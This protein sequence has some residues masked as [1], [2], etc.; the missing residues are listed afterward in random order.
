MDLPHPVRLPVVVP[1][2]AD[3][4]EAELNAAIAL[5]AR[6]GARRVIVSG[7]PDLETLAA[8]SLV[9]AQAAGVRFSLLRDA[10]TGAIAAIVGPREA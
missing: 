9:R 1:L 3:Q 2:E 6:G 10:S 7:L 8:S 4:V 5:V